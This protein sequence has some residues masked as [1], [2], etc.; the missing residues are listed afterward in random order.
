MIA[1][2]A[3][4]ILAFYVDG[5]VYVEEHQF[6]ILSR[7]FSSFGEFVLCARIRE[8]KEK[9]HKV[10]DVTSMIKSTIKIDSLLKALLG[11]YN[12]AILKTIKTCDLVIGR[13]PSVIAY[14]AFDGAKKMK[15]PFFA[16]S[17]GCAWD[18]YWNHGAK[19]KC[20]APYMFLKMKQVVQNADYALYV[21]KYFLQ[22]RY[23][24]R[25]ESISASNVK[26]REV[27]DD[28]LKKRVDRI[29]HSDF[30]EL[31]LTTTAAVDVKYKGQQFVIKAIP[32]LNKAGIRVR[33]ILIG[34]GDDS[35]LK[36]VATKNQVLDQVQFVGRKTHE[37][38][39][40]L[41]DKTDIYLQPS[42]QEGL[43]RSVIE[44]M[45]RGCPCIGARTAGI[46]E[47]ISPECVV[48]RKSSR[49]IANSI[50][51]IFKKDK[52]IELSKIN[53]ENSKDYLDSIL[54]KRRNEY[55]EKINV[56]LNS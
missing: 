53:F 42:L 37:E 46:P 19:G 7:Y 47:L 21:T 48:R 43:P 33:Y 30:K 23:P 27:R 12:K 3:T 24:C 41:L 1:F 50:I 34:N 5:H 20:I 31:V 9:P 11:H 6:S 36:K 22:K 45:S 32:L 54:T 8:L 26:I 39:F 55:Y 40:E 13:C 25:N 16:E 35:Y 38:V 56:D 18:A 29:S 14:R 10:C 44:A 17:M 2:I 51:A 52:M 49:E 4:D 28:V 15:K